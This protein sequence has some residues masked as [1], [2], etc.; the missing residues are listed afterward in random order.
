MYMQKKEQ[1]IISVD[2]SSYNSE[3]LKELYVID[4]VRFRQWMTEGPLNVFSQVVKGLDVP[5][6]PNEKSLAKIFN[7]ISSAV[8]TIEDKRMGLSPV[9]QEKAIHLL[10]DLIPALSAMADDIKGGKPNEYSIGAMGWKAEGKDSGSWFR[11]I[12]RYDRSADEYP[13]NVKTGELDS[14]R[15]RNK[16][17]RISLIASPQLLL[18]LNK[19]DNNHQDELLNL[20]KKGEIPPQII[21]DEEFSRVEA[22]NA[23]MRNDKK[24]VEPKKPARATWI[25]MIY[26]QIA[27]KKIDYRKFSK[28]IET[29]YHDTIF[30]GDDH[31]RTHLYNMVDLTKE[32][33]DLDDIPAA[34]WEQGGAF[35]LA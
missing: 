30:I 22:Y 17:A 3:Q 27:N 20:I 6:Y 14:A 26:D 9:T 18:L 31:D 1:P 8:I 35:N 19:M 34:N 10:I 24:D 11:Q 23:W 33:D 16:L 32:T 5:I 21:S 2:E 28:N 12:A 15:G 4:K 29:T 13:D 25:D 7:Y